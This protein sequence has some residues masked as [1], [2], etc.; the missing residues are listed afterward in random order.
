MSKSTVHSTIQQRAIAL[1]AMTQAV[2]LVDSIARKGLADAESCRTMMDSLFKDPSA[3]HMDTAQLYGGTIHLHTGLRICSDML[4]G[5][6]LPQNKTL[7]TY[8]A[9]LM[10]LE[11]KLARNS[12]IRQQ[13]ATG[14]QRINSQH[15]Y[16]GDAMHPSIIGAIA[17]LYGE[18]IS[19]MKPRIIVRGKSE[20]LAQQANTRRVRA[21]LMTGLRAAHLW[22]QYGGSHLN[23]MFRRNALVREMEKM[24][25]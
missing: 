16:F 14:M 20:H 12:V 17:E 24:Q 3:A 8:S 18:T 22:H 1:A 2:Y 9:G 5:D 25:G 6:N 13:L 21:L 10:A 15:H 11:R 7:M 19:T 4:K 23:L